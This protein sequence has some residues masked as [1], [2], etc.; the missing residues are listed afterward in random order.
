MDTQKLGKGAAVAEKKNR[1]I[2]Q[3]STPLLTLWRSPLTLAEF[4]ILDAYL[5]RIDSHQPE[6]RLVHFRKGELEELLGV[7]RI[8]ADDLK[9]RIDHLAVMVT[10]EDNQDPRHFVSISLFEKADCIQDTQG[11]W[12]V[13]L[14]CTPSAM[15]YIFN[16][17]NLGYLRYKLNAVI[18]L[19]SRYSY[20]LFMYLERNRFRGSWEVGI[21]DL[22]D[23][24][25]CCDDQYPTFKVFNNSI[26]KRC[27]KELE[28]KTSCRF[29]YE[30]IKKGRRVTG[31]RFNIEPLP[32]EFL[33]SAEE[34]GENP[35]EV[36][37]NAK[38]SYLRSACLL[39][40]GK[41]EF[42]LAEI[43]QLYSTL[44]FVPKERIPSVT[45]APIT[46]MYCYLQE[47]YAALNAQAEQNNIA[48]RFAYLMKMVK[49]DV[50]QNSYIVQ[51][52]HKGPQN[53]L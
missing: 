20:L 2:V 3:K 9:Q 10:V 21:N 43:K 6:N 49:N 51:H 35:L 53:H 52:P 16:I 4:K 12:Q 44:R 24:L 25:G 18:Y 33:D 7:K 14:M 5:S 27:K 30:T 40:N 13:D 11:M 37:K 28:E 45:G 32:S 38:L 29:I 46:A 31:V 50:E 36:S 48:H 26:L 15:K 42:S 47:K 17:D 22:R 19:N 39:P 41:P 34:L 23:F 1:S 8:N